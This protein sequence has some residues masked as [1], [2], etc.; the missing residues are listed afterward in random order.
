MMGPGPSNCSKRV[1]TAM[2]NTVLSN[3]HAE[4][5]R[6]MDEVKDGLRYIFQTENRATMCVS[7]SAHAGMEAMLSNLLEE[8]DRVLIAVNGIWAERAVEMSERYGADVRTIEG[9]PD[10]PFSL[11]T[12]ARAIELHQPKCLFL[13]HGD[14]SSGLLQP[15][16]GVGQI[17]H[18]HDCL[19]I[20]DAV[21]SLCGVPFYMDKWEIDAVYTGAQKVLGA[22]PGIT[23]IS[24]SPKALLVLQRMLGTIKF[25]YIQHNC[26]YP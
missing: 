12:L 25:V 1:L 11:E 19:L 18:Q 2:T 20:V 21:A 23:P 9:P 15:L 22:P 5:F 16:E 7:G 4:L 10:R 3:F 24:I 13:T 17:C 26:F 14:S 8:G 6:T